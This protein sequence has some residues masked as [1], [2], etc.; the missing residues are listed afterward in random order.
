MDLYH[1]TTADRLEDIL[2]NG[3]LPQR[4]WDSGNSPVISLTNSPEQALIEAFII[5]TTKAQLQEKN[6]VAEHY[7]VIKVITDNYTVKQWQIDEWWIQETVHP[8]DLEVV[9]IKDYETVKKEW[10]MRAR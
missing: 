9:I 6:R 2:T 7:A 3:L 8:R 1:G 4:N 10:N 5:D